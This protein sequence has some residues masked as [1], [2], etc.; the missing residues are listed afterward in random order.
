M[1]IAAVP[2]TFTQFGITG[3][4]VVNSELFFTI[5]P[6]QAKLYRLWV[7]V[8]SVVFE[9]HLVLCFVTQNWSTKLV[10]FSKETTCIRI[11]PHMPV[12]NTVVHYFVMYNADLKWLGFFALKFPLQLTKLSVYM[13]YR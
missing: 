7:D 13:L 1:L 4:D 10:P 3:F 8:V 11:S 5:L 6:H 9:V 2:K 12:I